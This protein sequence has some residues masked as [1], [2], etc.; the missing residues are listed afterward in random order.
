MSESKQSPKSSEGLSKTNAAEFVVNNAMVT[1]DA[2]HDW[3]VIRHAKVT[4]QQGILIF[5]PGFEVVNGRVSRIVTN[6]ATAVEGV[7]Q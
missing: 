2:G 4:G 7:K 3:I 1:K 6:P 5:L